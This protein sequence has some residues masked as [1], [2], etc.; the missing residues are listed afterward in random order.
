M[1]SNVN[2]KDI[3]ISIIDILKDTIFMS[4]MVLSNNNNIII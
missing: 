4:I 2:I 1:K 3:E